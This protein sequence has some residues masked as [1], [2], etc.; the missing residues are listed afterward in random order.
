MRQLQHTAE[1]ISC[2]A[3]GVP[4]CTHTTTSGLAR[5]VSHTLT[6]CLL[7]CSPV[8]LPSCLPAD[9]LAYSPAH[10]QVSLTSAECHV[11]ERAVRMMH[12]QMQ[13]KRQALA[14]AEER[15]VGANPPL[16]A[17]VQRAQKGELERL[18]HALV[19]MKKRCRTATMVEWKQ[20][21]QGMEQELKLSLE[22]RLAKLQEEYEFTKVG[23]GPGW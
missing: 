1:R 17:S 20:M 11:Y 23:W 6:F 12:E 16:F 9:M 2:Q 21:R 10:L 13:A 14:E 5:S 3:P 4:A 22:A 19:V 8:D 7:T 18:K 15:V